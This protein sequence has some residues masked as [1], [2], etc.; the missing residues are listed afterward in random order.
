MSV[1]S[2]AER[3]FIAGFVKT[4]DAV[5]AAV[6]AGIGVGEVEGLLGLPSVAD[7]MNA[8]IVSLRY[9]GRLLDPVAVRGLM[10]VKAGRAADLRELLVEVEDGEGAE[11]LRELLDG[12][13]Q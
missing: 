4:F 1:S 2:K 10:L 9:V 6:E 7:A 5:G 3:E 8:R 12:A 13:R 11:R